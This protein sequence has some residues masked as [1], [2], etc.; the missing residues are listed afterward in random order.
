MSGLS[1]L[2][3]FD[4]LS[5]GSR[6]PFRIASDLIGIKSLISII[7]VIWQR[8]PELE[9]SGLLPDLLCRGCA[10]A[11]CLDTVRHSGGR[12]G[13]YRKL[14]HLLLTFSAQDGSYL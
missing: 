8:L 13:G 11:G 7:S 6:Q 3:G 12:W 2:F 10:I 9:G 14:G 4:K 1:G 5:F